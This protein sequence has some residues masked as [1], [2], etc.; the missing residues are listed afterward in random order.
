M[1]SIGNTSGNSTN[2]AFN[3]PEPGVALATEL[4]NAGF[5]VTPRTPR[6]GRT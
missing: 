2:A 3:G 6:R 1:P 5:V 4:V